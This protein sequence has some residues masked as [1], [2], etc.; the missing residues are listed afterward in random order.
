VL[1]DGPV[2]GGNPEKNFARDPVIPTPELIRPVTLF[3]TPGDIHAQ[4]VFEL[5]L[6]RA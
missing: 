6:E 5:C 3:E 4:V 1:R 2:F